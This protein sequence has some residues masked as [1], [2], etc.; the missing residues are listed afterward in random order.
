ML[1]EKTVDQKNL[2]SFLNYPASRKLSE[3]A[4]YPFD[5]NFITPERITKY[6]AEACGFKLLYGTE[7]VTDAVM[8]ALNELADESQA[9]IKMKRMQ[10][11]ETVNFIENFPSE[12]RPALHTATR[13]FFEN[14]NASPKAQEAAK[15]A[16]AEVDKLKTFM[17]KIDADKKYDEMIMIG[18]GG[19]D[20]GPRANYYALQHMRKPD[21]QIYF[22]SNVDPDDTALVLRQV[23]NLKR[24]L[25]VVVSKSGKTLETAVNEEFVKEKFRDAGLN[26]KDH[27]ISITTPHS[28][29]DAP[30]S[31][32]ASF[33][34]W[35]WIGGRYSSTSMVGGVMLSF[36]LGFNI[37]WEFLRGAN[38]MDKAALKP[39]LKENL[40][41]LAALL[42][43]WNRDFLLYPTVALIPYSQ[44]LI[45]YPAHIQQVSMESNGKR[46]DQK[47]HS[48]TFE[49]SPIIWGEP[50]TNAQHSFFQLLHQGTS[51]V[52]VSFVG[53]QENQCGKDILYGGTTS[54]EKLLSNLFAQTIA[55]AAGQKSD[56]PNTFFPGNRP[57]NILLGKRLTPFALGALLSFYENSVAFQ[58]FIWGI[59][60]FDQEGVQLGKVLANKIIE[61]F[62]SKRDNK[63]KSETYP[64]GDAFM[65]HLNSLKEV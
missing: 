38:A 1:K 32:L 52:P 62:A 37:Y 16:R 46:I 7:A 57:T 14:P 29:M 34:L 64:I 10:S 47:G 35:D 59:N 22:I 53:F 23:K 19:S 41:L 40:P 60:S 8:E 2:S 42:G 18:I 56:N 17:T 48:V 25:V 33:Y 20:L 6:Y 51:I 4:E 43:I 27:F 61:R 65:N 45:R 24:C 30:E 21:R 9:I 58:G 26:P 13:D 5:L 63:S 54:Q 31:Y 49:T 50:G 36:V 39:S 11:G 3:L 12:N 44:A 28:P 55:M 15:L